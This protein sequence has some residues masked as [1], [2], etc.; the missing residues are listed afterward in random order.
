MHDNDW[1]MVETLFLL[2]IFII[3]N[4]CN[5]SYKIKMAIKIHEEEMISEI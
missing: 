5:L 4:Y 1:S 2:S 3:I